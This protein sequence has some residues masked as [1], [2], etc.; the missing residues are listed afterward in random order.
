MGGRRGIIRKRLGHSYGVLNGIARQPKPSQTTHSI[1]GGPN[2]S[3]G[4]LGA[5]GNRGPEE[6]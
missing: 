1:A 2:G 3:R 6:E 5:R 4:A